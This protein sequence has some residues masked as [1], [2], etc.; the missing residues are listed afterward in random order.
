M[1]AKP[2]LDGH[3][4]GAKVVAYLLKDAGMDVIYTGL[5]K[6]V[7]QIVEMAIQEDVDVIGLSVMTGGHLP[8]MEKLMQKLREKKVD[9]ILVTV[10]GV[11][12]RPDVLKLKELGA[13]AVFPGGTKF[14]EIITF[15]KEEA[16]KLC[17]AI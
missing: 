4:R 6:S 11:I 9:D 5:H 13:S 7:D 3:D 2:G 16:P 17:K 1:V 8:I 15:F 14:S 10:G 12:S